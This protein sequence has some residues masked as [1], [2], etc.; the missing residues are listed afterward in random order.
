LIYSVGKGAINKPGMICIEYKP[1]ENEEFTALIGKGVTFD[2]G[3]NNL[4][5]TNF[6]ESMFLD[7]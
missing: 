4:K 3:G 7:K 1:V 5:P 2:T 6:I